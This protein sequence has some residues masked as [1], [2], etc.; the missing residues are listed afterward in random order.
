MKVVSLSTEMLAVPRYYYREIRAFEPWTLIVL[1]P[2]SKEQFQYG[3]VVVL[4]GSRVR[5]SR[6]R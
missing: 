4:D 5:S 3:M 6:W 1:E 2:A